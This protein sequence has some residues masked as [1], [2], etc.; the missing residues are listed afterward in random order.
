MH[1]N[2]APL[3][4]TKTSMNYGF[5]AEIRLIIGYRAKWQFVLSFQRESKVPT[6]PRM[7]E[8]AEPCNT[9]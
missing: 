7:I 9:V 5:T 1:E 3:P 8:L 4:S 6:T 2:N